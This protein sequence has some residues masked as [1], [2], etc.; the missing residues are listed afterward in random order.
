[1][2]EHR[3][4]KDAAEGLFVQQLDATHIGEIIRFR[5][6]DDELNIEQI[7]TAELRQLVHYSDHSTLIVAE[8]ASREYEQKHTDRVIVRPY[9]DYDEVKSLL[10]NS[11]VT[12]SPM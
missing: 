4:D 3:A 2:S 10:G 8:Q 1:M 6:A 12:W 7:V 9:A 5:V 11:H